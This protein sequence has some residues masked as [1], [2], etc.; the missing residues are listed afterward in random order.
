MLFASELAPTGQCAARLFGPA[1]AEFANF[2]LQLFDLDLKCFVLGRLAL[3]KLQSNRRF[4]IDASGSKQI[5]IGQLLA[6][7]LK[8]AHL[9]Q[10]LLDEG[11]HAIIDF[12]EA[13]TH[14]AREI[15]L[16]QVWPGFNQPEQVEM[17]VFQR[18]ISRA[19]NDYGLPSFG[20]KATV[21]FDCSTYERMVDNAGTYVNYP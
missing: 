16:A 8:I 2:A 12:A 1:L 17:S 15:T 21:N 5:G 13:G 11:L 6:A 3:E 7:I 9:N 4:A 18:A 20:V 14:L 19:S 10:P